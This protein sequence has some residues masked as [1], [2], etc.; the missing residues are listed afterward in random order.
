MLSD[1][2]LTDMETGWCGAWTSRALLSTRNAREPL[3]LLNLLR[4]IEDQTTKLGWCLER[5]DASQ[6]LA[7]HAEIRALI[8][9]AAVAVMRLEQSKR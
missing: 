6:A 4:E 3:M 8:I 7:H 1:L 5:G 9:E 2:N